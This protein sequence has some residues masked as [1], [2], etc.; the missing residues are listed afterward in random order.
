[1][2]NAGVEIVET[3]EKLVVP[4]LFLKR[5]MAFLKPNFGWIQNCDLRTAAIYN[6]ISKIQ[7][8]SYESGIMFS[9]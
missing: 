2:Y 1:M 6:A 5:F 3:A 4:I 8:V 7:K 9:A